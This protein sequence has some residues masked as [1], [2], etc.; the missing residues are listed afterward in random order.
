MRM[1]I[2]MHDKQ[3]GAWCPLALEDTTPSTFAPDAWTALAA[4]GR[5]N[6]K[7]WTTTSRREAGQAADTLRDHGYRVRVTSS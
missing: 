1:H 4:D 7:A 2:E 5:E 3:D 6:H